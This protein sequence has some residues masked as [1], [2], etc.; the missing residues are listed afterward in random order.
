[1]A[2]ESSA[3]SCGQADN[4]LC[5]KGKSEGWKKLWGV[6]NKGWKS[7]SSETFSAKGWSVGG[8]AKV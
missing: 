8:E 2:W 5:E 1:L 6:I 3:Y 7:G 4:A